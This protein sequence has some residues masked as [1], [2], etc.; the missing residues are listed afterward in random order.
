M[1]LSRVDVCDVLAEI[2]TDRDLHRVA[3]LVLA[4]SEA[5]E[6]TLKRA[7]VS[8]ADKNI[9]PHDAGQRGLGTSSAGSCR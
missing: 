2:K 8:Q 7:S 4:T 5:R 1:N 9:H 6:Y 3:V